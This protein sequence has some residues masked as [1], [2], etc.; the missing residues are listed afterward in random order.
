MPSPLLFVC[1]DV[2][3]YLRRIKL[4]FL[5]RSATTIIVAGIITHDQFKDMYPRRSQVLTKHL[6]RH[7]LIAYSWFWIQEWIPE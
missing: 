7:L 6:T 1:S 2:H 3:A 5:V 4:N